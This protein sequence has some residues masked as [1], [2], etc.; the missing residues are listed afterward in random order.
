MAGDRGAFALNPPSL[1]DV[2]YE[3][4]RKRIVNGDIEPGEKL[5]EIRVATEYSVARPTA[6]A[7][8]ERLVALG[9]LRRSAH[10][11]AV[12]PELGR[13]DILDVF[14]A[15]EAV[16][17]FAVGILAGERNVPAEATRA[18]AA[19]ELAAREQDFPA[20]V[21]ADIRFHTAL[22]EATASPRL[23]KMHELII[24]EV[25]I[26]MGRARAHAATQP[27][28]IVAE[29]AAILSAIAGGRLEQAEAA[30]LRHIHRARDRLVRQAEA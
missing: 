29:H 26:T 16:E 22:V 6:K 23:L 10:K 20:Q 9:V 14:R 27:S 4:L 12:V 25:Q 17:G 1:A 19:I 8:L 13:E 7:C 28:K 3:S 21:E 24:G 11:S 5:T 30:L 15:R 18:Q 2:L